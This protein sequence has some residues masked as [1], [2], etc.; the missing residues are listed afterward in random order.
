MGTASKD[1]PKPPPGNTPRGGQS[2][3]TINKTWIAIIAGIL[4]TFTVGVGWMYMTVATSRPA[5]TN[6]GGY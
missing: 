5:T 6:T 3:I 1:T 2:Q 4:V